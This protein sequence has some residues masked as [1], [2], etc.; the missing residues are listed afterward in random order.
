MM[1]AS[2]EAV[3]RRAG[4][5]LDLRVAFLG[6][7]GIGWLGASVDCV[8]VTPGVGSLP[9]AA[10]FDALVVDPHP[11]GVARPELERLVRDAHARGACVMGHVRPGGAAPALPGPPPI[12]PRRFNPIDFR[13]SDVAGLCALI[14]LGRAGGGLERGLALMAE[15][16]EQ[17]P[18]VVLAPPGCALPALPA[19]LSR[20][21]ARGA[22]PELVAHGLHDYLGAIDHPSFHADV[23]ERAA[24][25]VRLCACGVPVAAEEV[26]AELRAL[27][28]EELS[29][30]LERASYRDLMDL[31]LRERISVAERRAALRDH[32]LDARWRALAEAAG[33]SVPPRPT[34]SVVLSTRRED[35]LD[36]ALEQISRQNYEPRELVVALHGDGFSEGVEERLRAGW[37]GTLKTVR[38]DSELT[39]GDA[40][41]AGVEAASGEYVTKMDD[42]D[43]YSV[44]HLWD[45]VL[46][47]E[48]SGADLVG[49]AAEF[50][51]LEEVDVTVRQLTRDIDSRLAG[52]AMMARRL[53]LVEVGGWP[54]LTRNEDR[55]L[56]ERFEQAGR[57]VHRIPPH[58][59]IL[60]RHG[61]DH[62]WRPYVDYFLFRSGRQWR[63]L[64]YDE[65]GI[66]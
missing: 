47:L 49:K 40:L 23:F 56:V 28:G 52:G 66:A 21:T 29:D 22:R 43:P 45:L 37:E 50:V 59:Y 1:P 35:W 3:S 26:S 32:S 54:S 20:A 51:Y 34:V 10:A 64:R 63:G 27:L 17:E 7:R 12:D 46:A 25:L 24:W 60:N 13:Q 38:V 19:R 39:L 9:D 48:Y 41:N 18:V 16:S 65:T 36:H 58:G 31:D 44:D 42:D 11:E 62:T 14:T 15:V 5:P 6:E 55:A 8:A 57:G 30:A 2:P 61:R 4:A 53:A 33:L